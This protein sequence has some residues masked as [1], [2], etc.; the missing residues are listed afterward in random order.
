MDICYRI[1]WYED[2]QDWYKGMKKNIEEVIKS[3][4]LIPVIDYK[5]IPEIDIEDIQ[6]KNYDLI[7]VDYNL[8]NGKEGI[9]G[10]KVI[11]HIRSGQIYTDVI[12]YSESAKLREVFTKNELEGVFITRRDKPQ[13]IQ[14][15]KDIVYKNLRRSLN[16]VNLRGI[17]MDNTSEFDNEMKEIILRAW[18]LLSE[19]NKKGI[20]KYIKKDILGLSIKGTNRTYETYIKNEEPIICEIL[21]DNIFDSNKKSRLLNK[22]MDLDVDYCKELKETFNKLSKSDDNFYKDYDDKIMKYRNALAHSKKSENENDIYL[23]KHGDEDIIFN[24]ELCKQI[25]KNLIKYS[26]IFNEL[27]KS[28]EDK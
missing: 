18:E 3:F 17:V 27:Y 20:D 7:L 23:G 26:S 22:I 25:R 12:F 4:D 19:E 24:K 2:Q 15:I 21:E 10:D 28:I 5:K 13:F 8:T 9:N 1:L 14:K 11:E 16:P 6:N